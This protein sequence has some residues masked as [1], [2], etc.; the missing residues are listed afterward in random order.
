M[1]RKAFLCTLLKLLCKL[2]LVVEIVK[3]RNGLWKGCVFV[4]DILSSVHLFHANQWTSSRSVGCA[5]HHCDL[6]DVMLSVVVNQKYVSM[7][8]TFVLPLPCVMVPSECFFSST[9][10]L[11]SSRNKN[12]PQHEHILHSTL[13]IFMRRAVS[14]PSL[15][16]QSPV[17]MFDT[18]GG[19]TVLVRIVGKTTY[20]SRAIP[21]LFPHLSCRNGYSEISVVPEVAR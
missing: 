5:Q 20:R 4:L 21:P 7:R 10:F 8:F 12:T 3:K 1:S 15:W 14:F 11:S 19:Q 6:L 2:F 13:L 17:V 18:A 9:A 16:C